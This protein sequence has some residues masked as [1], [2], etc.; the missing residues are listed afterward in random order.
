MSRWIVRIMLDGQKISDSPG[1]DEESANRWFEC[2]CS[3]EDV[4][5]RCSVGR[6]LI[7]LID[8]AG[9]VVNACE[10]RREDAS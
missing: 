1:R 6:I 10:V 3:N 8:P 4:P 9:M 5:K 7:Q 2:L